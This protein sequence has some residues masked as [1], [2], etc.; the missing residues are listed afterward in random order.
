MELRLFRLTILVSVLGFLTFGTF[1]AYSY[2][3]RNSYAEPIERHFQNWQEWSLKC[4]DEAIDASRRKFACS[5]ADHYDQSLELA[6]SASAEH[7]YKF[8][9]ALTLMLATPLLA[10]FLFYS[11]RWVISGQVRR[12]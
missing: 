10:I 3:Q 12:K 1:A 4:H 11:M 8:R 5:S 2:V 6:H 9:L 7:D